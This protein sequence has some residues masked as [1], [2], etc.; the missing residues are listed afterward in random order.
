MPE[1][2]ED[3]GYRGQSQPTT[4]RDNVEGIRDFDAAYGKLV[5][6]FYNEEGANLLIPQEDMLIH[7][8]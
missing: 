5:K 7:E 2:E 1:Q 4:G 6:K 8:Y 3:E